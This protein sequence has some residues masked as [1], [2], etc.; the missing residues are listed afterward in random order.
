MRVFI[1]N[2]AQPQAAYRLQWVSRRSSRSGVSE[3]SV[4]PCPLSQNSDIGERWSGP[5]DARSSALV[6]QKN[7]TKTAVA[8]VCGEGDR[9]VHVDERA[10]ILMR[11]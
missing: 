2:D 6:I 11:S 1:S 4:S 9:W 5:C 10:R 3:I 7:A 8:G